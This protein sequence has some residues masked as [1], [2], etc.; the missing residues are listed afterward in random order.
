VVLNKKLLL[1]KKLKYIN[2]EK[3]NTYIIT[4]NDIIIYINKIKKLT[5]DFIIK[6][7]VKPGEFIYIPEGWWHQ[8]YTVGNDN[9]AINFWWDKSNTLIDNGKEEFLIKNC[10]IS[11]LDKE[12][13]HIYK[14][15]FKKYTKL[16]IHKLRNIINKEKEEILI[17]YIFDK[18][19]K[20]EDYVIL[21]YEFENCREN[22][23]F[24][25][26]WQILNKFNKSENLLNLFD[27]MKQ[28]LSKRIIDK[29]IYSK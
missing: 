2:N 23:F 10:L 16:S 8:V 4:Q 11:L 12:I 25:S 27:K 22:S 21:Y 14:K 9:L 20:V 29:I 5:K 1:L 28:T 7:V 6:I 15:Y 18:N 24:E 13:T 3:Y 26:F 19:L 17:K